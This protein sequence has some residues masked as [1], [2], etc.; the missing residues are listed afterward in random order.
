[1]LD[2]TYN[3]NYS[4]GGILETPQNVNYSM[5]DIEYNTGCWKLVISIPNWFPAWRREG[6]HTRMASG[7]KCRKKL[8]LRCTS[9]LR[10]PYH[11]FQIFS[12]LSLIFMVSITT[13]S[14]LSY[15]FFTNSYLNTIYMHIWPTLIFPKH[16]F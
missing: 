12:I 16:V 5:G 8:H 13:W 6:N 14:Y 4:I 1:M 7:H 2:T 11:T 3:A 15:I 9:L 10:L